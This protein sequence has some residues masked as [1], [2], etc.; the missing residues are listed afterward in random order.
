MLIVLSRRSVRD[1]LRSHGKHSPAQT[2][3]ES[4]WNLVPFR[5]SGSAGGIMTSLTEQTVH[6]EDAIAICVACAAGY[7]EDILFVASSCDCPCHGSPT[8][9]ADEK[10]VE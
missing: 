7:H 3:A 10:L 4:V 9:C 6:E 1:V 8:R 2:D 5:A